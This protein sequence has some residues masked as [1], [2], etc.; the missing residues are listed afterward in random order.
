MHVSFVVLIGSRRRRLHRRCCCQHGNPSH[1]QM[2]PRPSSPL[3]SSSSSQSL[4][5]SSWLL[6]SL[7]PSSL[8]LVVIVATVVFVVDLLHAV[9]ILRPTH[10]G[11]APSCAFDIGFVLGLGTYGPSFAGHYRRHVVLLLRCL[12]LHCFD[13]YFS[14]RASWYRSVARGNGWFTLFCNGALE[15]N[16]P[17]LFCPSLCYPRERGRLG[18]RVGLPRAISDRVANVQTP[19]HHM[20]HY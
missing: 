10:V 11:I 19:Q 3:S 20:D 8:S 16:S 15:V 2:S 4:P 12:L 18:P 9:C 6:L 14:S 5:P 1:R 7:S 17:L 13:P